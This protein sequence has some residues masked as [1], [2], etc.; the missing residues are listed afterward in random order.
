MLFDVS[1]RW[2]TSD[3]KQSLVHYGGRNR[4]LSG[5]AAH[6]FGHIMGLTHENRIYNIMGDDG[7]HMHVNGAIARTYAGVDAGNGAEHLYGTR[8]DSWEDLG[9]AQWKYDRAYGEYS[10][11]RRTELYTA[12]GGNVQQISV[13][14]ETGYLVTPGQ[15]VRAEFMLENN[16]KSAATVNVGFYISTND[17]ISTLDRRIGGGRYDFPH[18]GLGTPPATVTIPSDLTIDRNYWLGII[19][20]ED[21]S[22]DER[23]EWNNATY[24]PLKTFSHAPRDDHGN[25]QSTATLVRVPSSTSGRLETG[26]DVDVFGFALTQASRLEVR[27][28]GSTDTVGSLYRDASRVDED[29]DGG[30]DT[31]FLIEVAAAQAGAYYVGVKGYT[32]ATT[33]SY[34]LEIAAEEIDVHESPFLPGA[35]RSA[36]GTLDRSRPQQSGIVMVSNLGG[37]AG[38]FM[39]EGFDRDGA[40]GATLL[41]IDLEPYESLIFTVYDLEAGSGTLGISPGLGDGSGDWRLRVSS[42]LPL[43]VSTYT[44]AWGHG[45]APL[46]EDTTVPD[47][48][49]ASGNGTYTVSWFNEGSNF[50]IRSFLMVVNAGDAPAEIGVGGRDAAGQAS[51][52]EARFTVP[53]GQ[54]RRVYADWLENVGGGA[55]SFVNGGLGDGSGRWRLTVTSDAPVYVLGLAIAREGGIISNLSR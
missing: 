51:M 40:P 53:P 35:P 18:Y 14:G 11:H 41:P 49:D 46:A 23:I 6:E 50:T 9:V 13:G 48:T 22:I 25:V 37:T 30:T 29:D 17:I 43:D 39:V 2:S 21:D 45:M 24:I 42:A 34:T 54:G 28:T 16:G 3:L 10:Q 27:T 7:T 4:L 33:G 19:V 5:T 44:G 15:I 52:G 32:T 55:P 26:G 20:D 1:R 36:D 38:E 8:S 47:A 31:N 12:G